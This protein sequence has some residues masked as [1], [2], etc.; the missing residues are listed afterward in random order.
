[1]IVVPLV[2][3]YLPAMAD[4][5]AS[6]QSPSLDAVRRELDQLIRTMMGPPDVTYDALFSLM[7][8]QL[9]H[10]AETAQDV[11]TEVQ[12]RATTAEP[13]TDNPAPSYADAIR[14]LIENTDTAWLRDHKESDPPPDIVRFIIDVYDRS[15][16]RVIATIRRQITP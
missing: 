4:P 15:S 5:P 11:I 6:E 7:P 13:P 8:G 16:E 9:F 1:M 14:W 12:L 10:I 3:L 2:F